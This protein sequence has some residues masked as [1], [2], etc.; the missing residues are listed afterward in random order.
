MSRISSAQVEENVKALVERIDQESFIYDLLLAYG[1]P[2]SSVTLLRKG[3]SNKAKDPDTVI[4]KNKLFFKTLS[5]KALHAASDDLRRDE[6]VLKHSPR[7]IIVTDFQTIVAVDTKTQEG[8]DIPIAELY[9]YYDFFLPWAGM[10][11]AQHVSENPADRKAAERMAKLYDE[12]TK[13]NPIKTK[14]ELHA[15][16]VFLCRVLFCFFA[17]DTEIFA[18]PNQFTHTI[19]SHTNPHGSDLSQFLERI[20]HVMALPE[21]SQDRKQYP[22]FIQAFPYVNGGLFK[23]NFKAPKFNSKSWKLF[24]ES[25]KLNWSEI[26]PDIFGS[27]M[28]AVV[29]T[30]ERGSLGMHYTSVPNIMKVI[31][32]LF[33]NELYEELDKAK[34]DQRKLERLHKRILNIKIFDPACGSGNFLIISYKELRK[35]EM[36]IYKAIQTLSPQKTLYLPQVQLT[37]F[38]GIEIDDFASEV[39]VLSL[40]LAE[41][42][43]NVKFKEEFGKTNPALPLGKGGKIVCQ[44]ATRLNWEEICPKEDS[45]V[46]VVGNPP[47]LGSFLQS[48]EQKSDLAFVCDG[49]KSY[50]D[51][52]Y[53]CCW[54]L[55]GADY[56]RNSKAELAFVTTN[57][58]SQGEQ[59]SLLWPHLFE[60]NLEIGFAHQSFKWK[61]S[62]KGNAG[63]ICAVISLR[64]PSNKPKYIFTE[65]TVAS[66]FNISPYLFEGKNTIAKKKVGSSISAIPKMS[67]GNK[68]VDDGNLILFKS[69]LEELLTQYPQAERYIRKFL[70]SSEFINSKERWCLWITDDEYD[71]AASIPPLKE[72]FERVAEF[73]AKSTEKST[74]EM[75]KYP[76][77]CYF[78]AHQEGPSI[79]IP[80]VS[81]E[82]REYIPIGFLDST[83]IISDLA[84][85]IYKPET[86]IFG[87]ISSKMHMVWVRA[88]GGRLKTDYRYS[89]SVCYNTF[90]IPNLTE[91]LKENISTHVFNV[92]SE[93]EKHPEK[94]LAELYDPDK[95][96]QGLREAHQ[97]LDTAIEQCYRRKPF[98]SDAERLE[99]LFKL[100]EQMTEE[101]HPPAAINGTQN[102]MLT[103]MGPLLD[104]EDV[105]PLGE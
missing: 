44:N 23:D 100:Y 1:H 16:N 30:S 34:D 13:E 66:A 42:Q 37:Q 11:K 63:V 80:R 41:H 8:L 52:D 78:I 21:N 7:F 86:F 47:Y 83:T 67:Y 93:R 51:L 96:P 31:E 61:N 89:S 87:V 26:N 19:E 68:I 85:V 98:N 62:A 3:T 95:M 18:K 76:Y 58:V 103:V 10:E 70:G 48:K 73:R 46:Y 33:L 9:Q 88:V 92:L 99:Y 39:A 6:A 94:T 14:E 102:M 71:A 59:V 12:I 75:A 36:E 77:K 101:A 55:K 29:H 60:K 64:N 90:P 22:A 2:K 35:L 57:S 53:I 32:P 24:V 43:M 5:G 49:F 79:I 27:M 81:S 65:Q 74:R 4:L 69:E 40:W 20:F 97:Q 50:K 91:A 38:F 54:F 56:I 25:G 45:E 105:L 28:Q 15:L 17:E 72:R 82:R 104:T 84:H